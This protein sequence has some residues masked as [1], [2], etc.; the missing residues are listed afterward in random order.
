[1]K[2]Y[3]VKRQRVEIPSPSISQS[4]PGSR[5]DNAWM[6][7]DSSK[8]LQTYWSEPFSVKP[9]MGFSAWTQPKVKLRKAE[10]KVEFSTPAFLRQSIL[11]FFQD[12]VKLQKFIELN[13]VEIKKGEDI[14]SM[15]KGLLYASLFDQFGPEMLPIFVPF[16]QKF[17]ANTE[18]SEQRCAA[19]MVFGLIKGSRFWPYEPVER[20]WTSILVPAFQTVLSNVT[21]ETVQDWE[22]CLSGAT[23]KHDANRLRWLFSILIDESKLSAESSQEGYAFSQ[24][25]YLKLLNKSIMQNWKLQEVYNRIFALLKH[26]MNHPYNKVRHQISSIMATIL[27]M[28]INYGENQNMGNAYP[29]LKDFWEFTQPKL[30]LNFH[31]PVI[32]GV[33]NSNDNNAMEVDQVQNGSELDQKENDRILETTA[34][35]ITQYIQTTSA[36]LRQD[37]YLALPYL[38]QFV[39]NETGQ[40]VSQTC[41]KSLCYLSVCITPPKSLTF[42]LDMIQK[43]L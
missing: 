41:L 9:E 28:D 36:S 12:P 16:V 29:S 8:D 4:H 32:N 15:D 26:Q 19:E 7:Y 14:F 35:W 31:N 43:V 34:L 20:L 37:M 40:E 10:D 22:I 6:Q 24:A 3:K 18:E 25:S 33:N 11:G 5:S 30:S 17:T 27:S 21:G 39:G 38:C 1:M 42:A 13:T 2:I 23:N